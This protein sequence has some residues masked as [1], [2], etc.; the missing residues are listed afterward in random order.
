MG[1]GSVHLGR[2][3]HPAAD[4]TAVGHVAFINTWMDDHISDAGWVRMS[5]IN[6]KG[7]RIWFEPADARLFEYNSTGPGARETAGRRRMTAEE[8]ARYTINNIFNGWTP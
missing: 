2:P 1:K 4:S 3:W 5:A 8:A 6:A 7:D